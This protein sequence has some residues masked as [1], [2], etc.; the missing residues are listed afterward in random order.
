MKF[1]KWLFEDLIDFG[2]IISDLKNVLNKE[3]EKVS[4]IKEKINKIRVQKKNTDDP[5]KKKQFND[6]LGGLNDELETAQNK[7]KELE[8]KKRKAEE[9]E[10]KSGGDKDSRKEDDKEVKKKETKDV[11]KII[12]DRPKFP[13]NI[14][15]VP[16]KKMSAAQLNKLKNY[17]RDM[18]NYLEKKRIATQGSKKTLDI[19]ERM[20]M[21]KDEIKDIEEVE[22]Q[23]KI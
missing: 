18:I 15:D 21:H 11:K 14:P 2:S 7:V 6:Q 19:A 5:K 17:H 1:K 13:D 22:I 4:A 10:N 3:R 20:T 12:D 16:L 9:E 8:E 23:L